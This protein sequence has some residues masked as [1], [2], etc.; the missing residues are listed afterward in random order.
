MSFW[1]T[2]FNTPGRHR[3][4][5][6][7]LGLMYAWVLFMAPTALS[8][9]GT[10]PQFLIAFAEKWR[11]LEFPPQSDPEIIS[12]IFHGKAPKGDSRDSYDKESLKAAK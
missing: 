1:D 4:M 3:I 7:R 9:I 2:P 12:S 6:K 11:P 10:Y 5:G 8:L